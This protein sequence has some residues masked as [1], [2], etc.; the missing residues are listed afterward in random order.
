MK[1]FKIVIVGGG[2]AGWFTAGW[3]S[4]KFP[5]IDIT[6][7]ESPNIPK[8]GVGESVTPHVSAFLNDLGVN[9]S[10]F[11]KNTGSIYKYANK[12]VDWNGRSGEFSYFSFNYSTDVSLLE[13]EIH[14]AT[15]LKDLK[16]NID[17]V[18]TTDT[19]IHLL[20]KKIYEKFD[21]QFNS[22]FHYMENNV[23]PFSDSNEYLLNPVF[24]RSHHINADLAA[25]YIRDNI[26]LPNKVKNIKQKVKNIIKN[27]NG[28]ESLL[29]DDDTIVTGNLFIDCSGFHKV[30]VNDW[31]IK[32]YK[33]NPIN[34][35]WVC[36]LDYDDAENEMVNYTQSIAKDFGWLFKIGLYHRMGSGYCFSSNYISDD[37]AREEYITMVKNRKAEP[38]LLKWVPHRLENF[39]IGNTVAIGL[40][41]G[42]VEPME[43]NALYV[44]INGIRR[45]DDVL[46]EYFK[47]NEFNFSLY[48]KKLSIAIDDIADFILV[49]YTLSS[50]RNND[51]WKDMNDL[52]IKEN[53]QDL[54]YEKYMSK[55]NHISY[56]IQGYSLFPEYMWA[57]LAHSWNIDLSKWERKNYKQLDLDLTE[58]HFTHLEKKNYIISQTRTNNY[59]WLKKNMFDNLSSNEWKRKYII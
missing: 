59:I 28:I 44:I 34:K 11:M 5:N 49:H 57:Q 7:I 6:L 35:A 3:F 43:A 13:K 30:L 17:T 9:N 47:T 54:L 10:H 52:G 2:S 19:L 8:I 4:K 12:F 41:G 1:K 16:F 15:T 36:Q 38:R 45:L 32:L 39:G 53:H 23:S 37:D 58:L 24:S 21:Q 51:F 33:N 55:Y 27:N 29:L 48:N 42:F 56:A 14:Y 25:E 40:S 46:E 22:Q 26:A 31:P 50:N 20:N 18:R